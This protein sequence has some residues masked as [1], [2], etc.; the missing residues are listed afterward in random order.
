MT[1]KEFQEW[2]E[3]NSLDCPYVAV[4]LNLSL[5]MVRRWKVN[6]T[7]DKHAEWFD[8]NDEWKVNGT[9]DKHADGGAATVPTQPETKPVAEIPVT[10][11]EATRQDGYRDVFV[12]NQTAKELYEQG[13]EYIRA[14][15][16]DMV[17]EPC[18]PLGLASLRQLIVSR[19]KDLEESF[20]CLDTLRDAAKDRD[21]LLDMMASEAAELAFYAAMVAAA[22]SYILLA[23][24]EDG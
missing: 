16:D 11:A 8:L 4:W 2:L 21:G 6:G 24:R 17:D 12:G 23:K 13:K 5:D 10:K 22:C 1:G 7:P 15:L 19:A 9:P 18:L 14:F 3:R 20:G